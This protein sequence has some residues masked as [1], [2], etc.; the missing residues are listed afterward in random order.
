MKVN[1]G[2]GVD[3]EEIEVV[4]LPVNQAK[5]FIMDEGISKTPGLMYAFMWYLKFK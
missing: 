4:Y 5:S 2:G 3:D 1:D